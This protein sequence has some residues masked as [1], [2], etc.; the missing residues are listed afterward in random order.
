MDLRLEIQSFS[1]L[2]QGRLAVAACETLCYIH[3]DSRGYGGFNR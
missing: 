3:D 1:I 2:G